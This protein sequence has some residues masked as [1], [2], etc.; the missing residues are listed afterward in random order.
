MGTFEEK[1]FF[2]NDNNKIKDYNKIRFNS[3]VNLPLNMIIEF[4][5]LTLNI[6][7]VIE[8]DGKYY[9]IIYLDEGFYVHL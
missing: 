8:K 3:N 1:L 9:S 7:C 4:R 5:P 6:C 2:G